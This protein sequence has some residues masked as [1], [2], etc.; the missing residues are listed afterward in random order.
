MV[1]QGGPQVPREQVGNS[2][3]GGS[4]TTVV[5]YDESLSTIRDSKLSGCSSILSACSIAS[6]VI[7]KVSPMLCLAA[8]SNGR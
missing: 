3:L 5:R 4:V 7:L 1:K 2:R 6:A 8:S